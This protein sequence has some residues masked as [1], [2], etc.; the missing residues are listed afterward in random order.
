HAFL[1]EL[2][3]GLDLR[4]RIE[5]RL[6]QQDQLVYDDPNAF[7][8]STFDSVGRV[9]TRADYVPITTK[10]LTPSGVETVT[11]YTLNPNVS[12]HR[13]YY[14]HNGDYRTAYKGAS[15]TLYKRLAHHWMVH[16]S[17]TYGDWYYSHAGDRPDPT[18]LVGGGQTDGLFVA[19]GSP[20]VQSALMGPKAGVF[21]DSKWSFAVD[22]MV[23]VAPERPWG[24]NVA[25]N[26]TGRQ[27][28]PYPFFVSVFN[29]SGAGSEMVQVGGTDANR[30]PNVYELDGRV[31]KTLSFR[32]FGLILALDCFNMLNLSTVLQR[33]NQLSDPSI[34]LSVSGANFVEEVQSPRI[35]RL[36]ARFVFK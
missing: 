1:P 16:G 14:L 7:D 13:G 21:I 30:L 20:V 29:V 19:P 10:V 2:V 25:G 28:Y 4:Y 31:S 12:T 8:P 34:P 3:A 15:L 9:A 23:Q 5:S 27:G 22:G 24:F 26:L 35:F 33:R 11:Y 6:L 36:G 32:R 18:I 17:V